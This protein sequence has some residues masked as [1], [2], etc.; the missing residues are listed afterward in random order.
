MNNSYLASKKF[1]PDDYWY[2][3]FAKSGNIVWIVFYGDQLLAEV[4][5]HQQCLNL[6]EHMNR[7]KSLALPPPLR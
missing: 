3:S 4:K 1:K 5:N 6:M 7:Q 2:D